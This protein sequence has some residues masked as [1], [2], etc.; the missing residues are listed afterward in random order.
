MVHFLFHGVEYKC[1]ACNKLHADIGEDFVGFLLNGNKPTS[2]TVVESG[3]VGFNAV[4]RRF[5]ALINFRET[6]YASSLTFT[7]ECV[8]MQNV[9]HDFWYDRM[10]W[11]ISTNIFRIRRT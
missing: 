6:F 7:T 8:H 11:A 2:L 9:I 5:N 10:V 1:T 4:F 3:D